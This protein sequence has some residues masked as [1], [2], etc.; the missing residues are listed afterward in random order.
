MEE[1]TPRRNFLGKM[2]LAFAS[3]FASP[4][5][6]LSKENS[7]ET[8]EDMNPVINIKA[9][10][11]QWETQDPFLF[12]VHHEDKFPKGNEVM[13][14]DPT[15]FKG[16]H[17]GEDF[18][19]K[20]GFRM[21]HGKTVPGFPGHPHRGF[22]TITVVRQGLVDHA[23]SLGAAGR[24]GDGDVQWMTAGKGV[25]HSEMFPL[26][27]Q[28]KEN[29]MELFQIWLNLPKKHKMVEPHFK[30]LWRDSIPNYEHTDS[31]KKKTLVEVIA[32]SLEK[33]NAPAPPPDSWA[34]DTNNE[35]AVWNI[36]MEAG[37]SWTLPKASKGVNRS[38]Y[39][40]EGSSL[41]LAGQEIEAYSAVD[42]KPEFDIPLKAGDQAVSILVLQGRP[43]GEQVIQYGPFVMNTKDEIKQAFEDYHETQFGGWPWPKFDQVHDRNKGRFA[44]H[45]DGTLEEKG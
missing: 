41:N 44:K 35:V 8:K 25:Q 14:P 1:K 23:D 39:F 31:A 5:I 15:N 10:G 13:G 20:D 38:I 37:T 4:L 2:S 24:Y 45:A 43:I 26:I 29:P 21:Y 9:L 16:R 27:H 7:N 18:I 17:M 30:M 32:G 34:A 3:V 28:D 6:S 12:C 19:I 33:H 22:E 36:K 11:F 42:L 40:Y